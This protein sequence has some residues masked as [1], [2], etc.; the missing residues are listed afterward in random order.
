MWLRS[1]TNCSSISLIGRQISYTAH[2]FYFH[3]SILKKFAV[4]ILSND[5]SSAAKD[6]I[7]EC[8]EYESHI[9]SRSKENEKIWNLECVFFASCRLGAQVGFSCKICPI[10]LFE[11]IVSI[12]ISWWITRAWWSIPRRIILCICSCRR[13]KMWSRLGTVSLCTV[14]VMASG[15]RSSS[16]PIGYLIGPIW[17]LM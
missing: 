7:K 2:E 16:L 1:A 13:V 12:L 14:Y 3:F 10:P 17:P 15:R 8:K 9:M 5:A 4:Q 11:R 6:D